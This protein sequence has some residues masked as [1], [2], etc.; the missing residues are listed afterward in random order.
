MGDNLICLSAIQ[1]IDKYYPIG[2]SFQHIIPSHAS[3]EEY[4]YNEA[5]LDF[6]KFITERSG[7]LQC[8]DKLILERYTIPAIYSG[9][10]VLFDENYLNPTFIP[11]KNIKSMVFTI[12]HHPK[13]LE[14]SYILLDLIK[15][16]FPDIKYYVAFHSKPN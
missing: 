15:K 2:C 7:A 8:W 12:Q 5:T 10:M 6:L 13:Y 16:N 4:E 11:P 3:F 14:Q 1:I 9:D